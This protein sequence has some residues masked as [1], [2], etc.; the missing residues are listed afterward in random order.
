[1]KYMRKSGILER[2]VDGE[3]LLLDTEADKVHQLNPTASVIWR[4]CEDAASPE[5]IAKGL[6]Q[7]FEVPIETAQRDATDTLKQFRELGLIT[8]FGQGDE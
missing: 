6:F 3:M 2:E 7:Q 5:Q 1:M 4:L 8:E